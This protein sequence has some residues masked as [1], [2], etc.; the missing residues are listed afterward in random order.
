[1]VLLRCYSNML[2]IL[3]VIGDCWKRTAPG[4]LAL[5]GTRERE[6]SRR[7]NTA[8]ANDDDS[9]GHTVGKEGVSYALCSKITT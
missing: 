9:I 8:D 3:M 5:F 2:L 1:M 6:Y 4:Q 7:G